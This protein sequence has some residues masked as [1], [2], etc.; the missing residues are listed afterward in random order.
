MEFIINSNNSNLSGGEKRRICLLRT[1]LKDSNLYI[2]DEPT[3]EIDCESSKSIIEYIYSLRKD[4][5]VIVFT[6]DSQFDI[7]ADNIFV[8]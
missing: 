8:L 6:H 4:K 5:T 3:S 7:Y 1:L 2:L